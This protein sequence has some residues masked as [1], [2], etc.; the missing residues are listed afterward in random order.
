M[1]GRGGL[2][3]SHIAR[4]LVLFVTNVTRDGIMIQNGRGGRHAAQGCGTMQGGFARLFALGMSIGSLVQ[5]VLQH[6]IVTLRSC[7]VQRRVSI[8]IGRVEGYIALFE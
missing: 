8:A 6:V 5:Q 2:L 7:H 3:T 1:L 4:C